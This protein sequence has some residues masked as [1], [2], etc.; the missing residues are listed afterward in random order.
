M[1]CFAIGQAGWPK[2]ACASAINFVKT[3]LIEGKLQRHAGGKLKK[4]VLTYYSVT[5]CFK[6]NQNSS[7]QLGVK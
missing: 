4:L 2:F 6:V 5:P 3:S 7:S 1:I